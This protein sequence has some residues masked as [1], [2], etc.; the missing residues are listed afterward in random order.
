MLSYRWRLHRF[1]QNI[2]LFLRIFYST[3]IFPIHIVP[4]TCEEIPNPIMFKCHN[5]VRSIIPIWAK[6]TTKQRHL[7]Y[8]YFSLWAIQSVRHQTRP[9][10]P[11]IIAVPKNRFTSTTT[12]PHLPVAI[13]F[14]TGK[15]NII[16]EKSYKRINIHVSLY[17]YGRHVWKSRAKW[18]RLRKPSAVLLSPTTQPASTHHIRHIPQKRMCKRL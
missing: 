18:V 13:H 17:S 11:L 1:C 6:Q 5:R 4:R 15:R 10:Q 9:R 16:G 8:L 3:H 7:H 2:L 14:T 12:S